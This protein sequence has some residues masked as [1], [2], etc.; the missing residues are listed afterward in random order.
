MERLAGQETNLEYYFG[1]YKSV[2]SFSLILIET[3]SEVAWITGDLIITLVSILL[4]RYYEALH[5]RLSESRRVTENSTRI[6]EELHRAQLAISLLAQRVSE[7]FSALVSITVACNM[8][9]I[10]AF[11]FSGLEDDMSDPNITIRFMFAFSFGY[12]ILRFI[13][14]T[15]LASRLSEMV[16]FLFKNLQKMH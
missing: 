3:L 1:A 16:N 8:I 9:Y 5:E 7:T 15:Y 14:S 2:Y 10:L 12:L 11:L 6:L 13:L 4:H